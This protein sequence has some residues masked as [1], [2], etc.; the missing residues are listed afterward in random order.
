MIKKEMKS[1][2]FRASVVTNVLTILCVLMLS[3]AASAQ[4]TITHFNYPGHGDAWKAYLE[5]RAQAFE[6]LHPEINID[7]ITAGS[8][9]AYVE[10]VLVML[11]GG[12]P[13]DTTD[14]HAALAG[15]MINDGTFA[16]LRSYLERD[17]FNLDELTVPAVVDILTAPNGQIWSLAGDLYTVSTFFNK[18]L[19]AEAGL[20]NPAELGD[21][22]TWETALESARRLTRDTTGDGEADQW[23]VDRIFARWYMW[24]HQAGGMVY[25]RTVNPT[26]S[27]WNS[28]EVREGLQFPLSFYEA[29]ATPPRNFPNLS[30]TYL[31]TG[32]TAFSMVDGPGTVGG[33]MANVSFDWD[34]AR[35]VRGPENGGSEI[36]VSGFQMLSESKHPEEAWE[37]LKF[38]ALDPD[39]LR[40]FMGYTGRLPGLTEQ[41]LEYGQYNENVPENW[42]AFFEVASDPNSRSNYV[43]PNAGAVNSIVNSKLL[44][45]F[46]GET[47]LETALQQIHEGVS[48]V[49]NDRR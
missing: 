24:V 46:N 28:E 40:T 9:G 39:S 33:S 14:F 25:D 36:A 21:D 42:Q 15:G 29:E 47:A 35:Q 12:T 31:W 44:E 38:I 18:N 49:L 2:K 3:V 11:A 17:G 6:E 27:K 5:D 34:I 20:A 22:W 1:L 23:G 37:W 4:V 32:R 41:I 13:P 30:S 48:A 45:V 7:I 10:S 26:E 19:F 43:I 16:D 8:S